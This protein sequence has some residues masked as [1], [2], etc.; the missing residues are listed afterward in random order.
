MH[1]VTKHTII[2]HNALPGH[3]VTEHIIEEIPAHY[4]PAAPVVPHPQ[5]MDGSQCPPPPM[6]SYYGAAV[7]AETAAHFMKAVHDIF[8]S[9]LWDMRHYMLSILNGTKDQKYLVTKLENDAAGIATA[10]AAHLNKGAKAALSAFLLASVQALHDEAQT[11]KAGDSIKTIQSNYDKDI[12]AFA[13]AV[14]SLNPM[15]WPKDA[16][17]SIFTKL[18][19]SWVAQ[20]EAR[21][22]GDWVADEAAMQEAKQIVTTGQRDGTPGFSSIFATG[23]VTQSPNDFAKA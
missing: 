13:T 18:D 23:I 5:M 20:I 1:K 16:V 22:A 15:A 6:A 21:L 17:A 11:L 19:E 7:P 8:D 10:G 14:N 4:A 9:Y 12:A 3:K 2:E